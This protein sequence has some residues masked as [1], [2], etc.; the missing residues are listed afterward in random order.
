MLLTL[1]ERDSASREQDEKIFKWANIGGWALALAGKVPWGTGERD[2][3]AH[4]LMSGCVAEC[5]AKGGALATVRGGGSSDEGCLEGVVGEGGLRLFCLNFRGGVVLYLSGGPKR[6]CRPT[7]TSTTIRSSFSPSPRCLL[8]CPL[9]KD[10]MGLKLRVRVAGA[11]AAQ[12]IEVPEVCTL[13]QLRK[14]VA[15]KC[16]EGACEPSAV[17]NLIW[18][19][20]CSPRRYLVSPSTRTR[21]VV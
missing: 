6:G 11:A 9:A 8:P 13:A 16:Y 15:T 19:T 20:S 2:A 7:T 12:S 17:G 1:G 14:A 18:Q 4:S 21:G 3:G 5:R 10:V